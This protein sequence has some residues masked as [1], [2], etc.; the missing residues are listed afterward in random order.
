MKKLKEIITE[1]KFKYILFFWI[2]ISI[3]FV[4]GSNLQNNGRLFSSFSNF[5]I[6]I[7]KIVLF[8]II[9]ISIL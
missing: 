4:F 1:K 7:I 2:V 3:Q 9:F 5:L 6:D 8:T